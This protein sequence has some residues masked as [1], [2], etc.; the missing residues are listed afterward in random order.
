MKPLFIGFIIENF[1][2]LCF[3]IGVIKCEFKEVEAPS[4]I[5]AIEIA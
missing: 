3:E 4:C 5:A 2:N 1:I